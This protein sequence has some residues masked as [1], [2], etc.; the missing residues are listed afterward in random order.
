[1]GKM[2]YNSK[3][4]GKKVVDTVFLTKGNVGNL[5]M[6]HTG[7]LSPM[8]GRKVLVS[9]TTLLLDHVLDTLIDKSNINAPFDI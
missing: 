1:M 2:W 3:T 8:S 9:S 6:S 5:S 4:D 7:I